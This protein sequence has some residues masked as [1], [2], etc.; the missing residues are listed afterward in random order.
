MRTRSS[1]A[2]GTSDFAFAAVVLPAGGY[3][4]AGGSQSGADVEIA[5]L[6]MG[7]ASSSGDAVALDDCAGRR[8]DTVVYGPD[9]RDGFVDDAGAVF[10]TPTEDH[11]IIR[12][13][14]VAPLKEAQRKVD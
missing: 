14:I 12:R 8:A 10:G 5:E 3:L 6:A 13:E 11:Q 1:G 2:L 9:N 7:N 4:V